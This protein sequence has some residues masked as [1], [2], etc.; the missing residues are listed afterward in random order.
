MDIE[1]ESPIDPRIPYTLSQIF[2]FHN[3]SLNELFNKISY[4]D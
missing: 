1:F 3:E 2:K 4:Q